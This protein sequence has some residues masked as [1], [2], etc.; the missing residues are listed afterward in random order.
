MIFDP[1]QLAGI[2][3]F[4]VAQSVR[5]RKFENAHRRSIKATA[6]FH[7][8]AGPIAEFQLLGQTWRLRRQLRRYKVGILT[9]LMQRQGMRV[10]K[11]IR[12]VKTVF[13]PLYRSRYMSV[14]GATCSWFHL[15]W[16]GRSRIQTTA[17]NICISL[18]KG[19]LPFHMS[20]TTVPSLNTRCW[21]AKELLELL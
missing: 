4:A 13:L 17:T 18:P 14:C 12:P 21:V 3:V 10:Q 1:G 8:A 7:T 6:V 19:R 20:C 2:L 5:T 15:N 16:A 11:R 9:E